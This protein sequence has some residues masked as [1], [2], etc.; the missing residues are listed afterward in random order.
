MHQSRTD[1]LR[2]VTCERADELRGRQARDA[3]RIHLGVQIDPCAAQPV[4]E[5][6]AVEITIGGG[7]SPDTR[8][9]RRYE[10]GLGLLHDVQEHAA[11]AQ[12]VLELALTDLDDGATRS[13]ARDDLGP[14]VRGRNAAGS[15]RR[16][17]RAGGSGRRPRPR[18]ALDGSTPRPGPRGG[19]ALGR[20][21]A[22]LRRGR[23]RPPRQRARLVRDGQGLAEHRRLVPR[24]AGRAIRPRNRAA[25]RDPLAHPGPRPPGPRTPRSRSRLASLRT[26]PPLRPSSRESK[27]PAAATIPS[28]PRSASRCTSTRSGSEAHFCCAAMRLRNWTRRM[29]SGTSSRPMGP[30]L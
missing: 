3:T 4:T 25:A 1:A 5:I 16:R 17:P 8:W 22:E 27:P 12:S 18:R 6:D 26:T 9:R 14:P 24:P 19:L 13:T 20:G 10:H 15:I 29:T 30:V 28:A 21:C 2:D 23:C 7:S 11:E